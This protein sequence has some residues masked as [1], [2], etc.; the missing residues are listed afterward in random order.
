MSKT[1][2]ATAKFLTVIE[3]IEDLPEGALKTI[4]E[5]FKELKKVYNKFYAC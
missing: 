4:K 2:E 5:S 3:G 1:T